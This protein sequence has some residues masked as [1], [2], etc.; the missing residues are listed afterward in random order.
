MPQ[1]GIVVVV[2]VIMS[3]VLLSS[4]GDNSLVV[5]SFLMSLKVLFETEWQ[6]VWTN[7]VNDKLHPIYQPS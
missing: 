7:Y 2:V 5:T 3:K 4:S 6:D 1:L